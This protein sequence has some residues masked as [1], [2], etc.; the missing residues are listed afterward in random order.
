MIQ[1]EDFYD[2][3]Y[4]WSDSLLGAVYTLDSNLYS[5]TDEDETTTSD[6]GSSED[7]DPILVVTE[8]LQ[9]DLAMQPTSLFCPHIKVILKPTEDSQVALT[10]LIDIGAMCSFIPEACVPK[11][12]YIPTKVS[13]GS[14]SG[15]NFY[16]NKITRPIE[17]QPFY[18]QAWIF[19]L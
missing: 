9:V 2:E 10:A 7:D 5:D 1:Q 13:F 14:A 6:E 16:S 19:C 15:S 3:V 8:P 17:I 11:E 4:T 18:D 12:F